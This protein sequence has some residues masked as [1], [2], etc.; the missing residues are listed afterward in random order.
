MLGTASEVFGKASSEDI[1]K[2]FLVD[3]CVEDFSFVL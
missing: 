2:K 3:N 1:G